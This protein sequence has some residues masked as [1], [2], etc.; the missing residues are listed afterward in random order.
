M[1]EY[2]TTNEAAK[3][4]GLEYKTRRTLLQALNNNQEANKNKRDTF[5]SA[6]WDTSFKR[7]GKRYFKKDE[8]DRILGGGKN[9]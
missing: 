9:E 7:K 6:I 3:L 8:I 1:I 2:Y 4:K 5:L